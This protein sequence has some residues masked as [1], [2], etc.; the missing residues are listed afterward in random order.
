M[1]GKWEVV[2]LSPDEWLKKFLREEGVP[3][4]DI[5]SELIKLKENAEVSVKTRAILITPEVDKILREMFRFAIQ[6]GE[7]NLDVEDIDKVGEA[8]WPRSA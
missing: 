7:I 2:A 1:A 4:E 8:L 3:E 6:G 5:E